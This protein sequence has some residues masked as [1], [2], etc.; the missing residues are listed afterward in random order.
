MSS[1]NILLRYLRARPLRYL[2]FRHIG[3]LLLLIIFL[4]VGGI[5]CG[6]A[7]ALD[8]EIDH[9]GVDVWLIDTRAASTS[10][11]SISDFSLLRYNRLCDSGWDRLGLDDFLGDFNPEQP[12]V[13]LIHGNWMT[14][15]EA[16][17]FAKRFYRRSRHV[18]ENCCR[19]VFWSWPSERVLRG[20]R[21]DALLKARRS[22]VEADYLVAFLRSLPV[23]S[24]VSLVGFSFGGRLVCMAL[25]ELAEAEE[26]SLRL[27]SALLAPAF[28][29]S[30]LASNRR[31]GDA[32]SVTEKM[33]L[34]YNPQ[35]KVLR[36][37]PLLY[38]FCGPR[39]QALG[40]YGIS[41]RSLPEEYRA[42]FHSINAHR[43]L[44]REHGFQGSLDA[45]YYSSRFAEIALFQ[46]P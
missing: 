34:Y 5:R 26:N 31:F 15:Q 7:T 43:A 39:P 11:A 17:G 3:L 32:L 29:T 44:G 30:W 24:R 22:D 41:K 46:D 13:V 38:G 6:W 27:R 40:R 33:V 4:A 16:V 35:D 28:D 37:Y 12:L 19:V 9:D 23:E 8:E 21:Q 10:H 2:P 20:L 36:F 18:S 25:Q 42:K 14:S 1:T 45:F